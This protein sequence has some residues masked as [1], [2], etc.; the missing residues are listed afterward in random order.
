MN[1]SSYDSS[2]AETAKIEQQPTAKPSSAARVSGKNNILEGPITPTLWKFS[3]PLMIGFFMNSIYGW[4]DTYFVSRLGVSAIAA[5]GFA[6]QLNFFIFNFGSGFAIGASIIV[7]R[8]IGEGNLH[9]AEEVTRQAVSFVLLFGTL[10]AACLFVCM[11]FI[12]SELLNLQG[13]PLALAQSY[14]RVVLFGVPG[15]FTLF[16]LNSIVRA[17][18]NSMLAMKIIISTVVLNSLLDPLFIFGWGPVPAMGIAGAALAT[19]L[20]QV[21]GALLSL[22]A[23]FSGLAGFSIEKRVPRMD[24]SIIKSIIRLGLPAMLQ[25]FSISLSR[26]GLLRLANT[27][28]TSI[29]AAY[30]LGMKADFFV[31]MPIFAV[32]VA[33]EIITGQHLGAKKIDRIFQFYRTAIQ[34]LSLGVLAL[35]ALVYIFAEKFAHIFTEEP[36]VV[37][38]VS[39]YLRIVAFS[40]PIF[41]IGIVSTRV[42]SGA[43]AAMRSMFIVAGSM[44]CIM[45]P[46]AYG[47]SQWTPLRE[48][49]LWFGILIGYLVFAVIAYYNVRSKTWLSAK[50]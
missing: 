30:T 38:A 6:E 48:Q 24:F 21:L 4:V 25:M 39:T 26:M 47:L 50:V 22:Y 16:L 18:G 14:M 28:G 7:A 9:A 31:F 5:M 19:A 27:F 29:V 13:E 10:T 45:L 34:Q 17:T 41:V 35:S 8:R 11:P 23:L 44:L 37:H 1:D 32:G 46:L 12:L 2:T 49:G 36:E 33:I 42:I 3:V 43:G 20:A 15:L 40:Y